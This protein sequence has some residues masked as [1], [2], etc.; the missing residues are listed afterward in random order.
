MDR[1]CRRNRLVEFARRVCA[2]PDPGQRNEAR[3]LVAVQVVQELF[4]FLPCRIGGQLF[5]KF[6][7][8]RLDRA[9]I[10]AAKQVFPARPGIGNAGLRLA[11]FVPRP[12][13]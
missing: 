3:L 8:I 4:E 1:F 9:C 10:R 12:G 5:F 13:F 6:P 11:V 2:L 7:G